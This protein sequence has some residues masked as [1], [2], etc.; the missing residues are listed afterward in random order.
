MTFLRTVAA[1]PWR[2]SW[3]PFPLSPAQ[4]AER[5]SWSWPVHCQLSFPSSSASPGGV[6]NKRDRAT[7]GSA[8]SG[9]ELGALGHPGACRRQPVFHVLSWEPARN[10][11]CACCQISS[12]NNEREDAVLQSRKLEGV[13]R[14]KSRGRSGRPPQGSCLP[15]GSRLPET[16]PRPGP[17]SSQSPG[18]ALMALRAFGEV[19][20][21]CSFS[22]EE[23]ASSTSQCGFHIVN[24]GE[25]WALLL[26]AINI[27]TMHLGSFRMFHEDLVPAF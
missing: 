12:K 4:G 22:R 20:G 5:A 1:A 17:G 23:L 13:W 8:G 18:V 27:I 16:V 9:R 21:S 19:V 15:L 10:L 6:T 2:C 3:L 14:C 11:F 25:F 24:G 26:T 7:P